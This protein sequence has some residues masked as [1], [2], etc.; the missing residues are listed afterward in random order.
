MIIE[1][2]CPE[3]IVA[4]H[5]ILSV[6]GNDRMYGRTLI[7]TLESSN[8]GSTT[9]KI[10]ALVKYRC[11]RGYKVMGESISTCEDTGLWS[12]DTPHCQC[13][14]S[15]H[16]PQTLTLPQ[17]RPPFLMERCTILLKTYVL[18]FVTLLKDYYLFHFSTWDNTNN[19][20]SQTLN[21]KSCLITVV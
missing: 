19:V 9:Y 17:N 10:G 14:S 16:K 3:P 1:I 12:G 11:E 7:R 20:I 2:R 6:T 21:T 8:S 15:F 5:S 4:E 18:F 13:M